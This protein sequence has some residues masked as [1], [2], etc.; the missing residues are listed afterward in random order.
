MPM[1]ADQSKLLP[2]MT[3]DIIAFVDDAGMKSTE[4]F[5]KE[6]KLGFGQGR[7]DNGLE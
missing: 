1:Y 6:Q 4:H 3:A 7:E 5:L 2:S